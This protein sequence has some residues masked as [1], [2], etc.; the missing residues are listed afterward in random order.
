[1]T[2][3]PKEPMSI[4]AKKEE[5]PNLKISFKG[6]IQVNTHVSISHFICP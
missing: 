1:M 2:L 3:T 4:F 6:I 5:K